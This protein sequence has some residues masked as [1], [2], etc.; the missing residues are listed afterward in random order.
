MT[1]VI[2]LR[3]KE[4]ELGFIKNLSEK[5]DKDK[6]FAARQLINYGWTY[7]VLKQYKECKISIEKAAKELNLTITEIIE[8]LSELGIKSP[9]TYEEYLE[10]YKSLKNVF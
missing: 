2:T 10:G 3:L 9:L 6:F 8:L 5:E 1:K 4:K 7:F